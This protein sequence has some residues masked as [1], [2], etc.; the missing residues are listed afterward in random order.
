ME[1]VVDFRTMHR[2]LQH[3]HINRVSCCH[4]LSRFFHQSCFSHQSCEVTGRTLF[5]QPIVSCKNLMLESFLQPGGVEL[6]QMFRLW[7]SLPKGRIGEAVEE[8][9]TEHCQSFALVLDFVRHLAP[10]ENGVVIGEFEPESLACVRSLP[11]SLDRSFV[12]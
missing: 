9:G 5:C 3:F 8:V 12:E 6:L 2:R 1:D 4:S 7:Q 10:I 11:D